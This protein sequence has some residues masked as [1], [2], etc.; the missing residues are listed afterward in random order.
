M[1]SRQN[2]ILQY[3]TIIGCFSIFLLVATQN[4]PYSTPFLQAAFRVALYASTLTEERLLLSAPTEKKNIEEPKTT[5]IRN[6]C[7]KT[8]ISRRK[9]GKNS[10]IIMADFLLFI[11]AA[12]DDDGEE[13]EEVEKKRTPT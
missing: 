2:I 4:L 11:L 9:M 8:M 1:P 10:P 12:D 13:E 7:V 5:E 6:S 3:I